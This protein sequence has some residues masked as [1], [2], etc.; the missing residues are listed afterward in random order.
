MN[1]IESATVTA[2]EDLKHAS[3]FQSGLYVLDAQISQSKPISEV[4]KEC[5]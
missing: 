4:I 5:A 3:C 1:V 2:S